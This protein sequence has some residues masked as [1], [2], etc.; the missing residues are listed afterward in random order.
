MR[1]FP[2]ARSDNKDN[3]RP[4]R[5][6]GTCL[7]VVCHYCDKAIDIKTAEYDSD[8]LSVRCPECGN[9]TWP[10]DPKGLWT[11]HETKIERGQVWK[12][13]DSF[14]FILDPHN[15][16]TVLFDSRNGK[17]D[18]D[19]CLDEW[20]PEDYPTSGWKP[21]TNPAEAF[22][23]TPPDLMGL[24]QEYYGETMEIRPG[25][26]EQFEEGQVWHHPLT[27]SIRI[28]MV[29]NDSTLDFDFRTYEDDGS[30]QIRTIVKNHPT[31]EN[32]SL[33][34][35][36]K[37]AQE[38]CPCNLHTHIEKFYKTP[39]PQEAID[40]L[41][42]EL[43]ALKEEVQNN[44]DMACSGWNGQGEFESE[45]AQ[46]LYELENIPKPSCPCDKGV[47]IVAGTCD[48][49]G[50]NFQEETGLICILCGKKT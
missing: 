39:N 9:W 4:I 17:N 38:L 27:D 1:K 22:A 47:Y 5:Q 24:V 19:Q 23:A 44:Y 36:L 45:T 31:W 15:D 46:R 30:P 28:I 18:D 12:A 21:I 42:Q 49:D 25:N 35:T 3:E 50:N 33:I 40:S 2:T 37:E 8:D 32:Y 34:P 43:Q 48:K 29:T 7:F 16:G 26:H 13:N 10:I 11:N 41:A 20:P 14:M 6:N